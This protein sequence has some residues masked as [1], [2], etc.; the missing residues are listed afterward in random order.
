MRVTESYLDTYQFCRVPFGV[1]YSPFLLGGTIK[2]HL[3]KIGTPV[4]LE[5]NDNIYIDNVSLGANS[6]EEA[7]KIYLKSKD[8]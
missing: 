4:A 1:V 3:R 7:H 8:F 2:F 5:I 6:V